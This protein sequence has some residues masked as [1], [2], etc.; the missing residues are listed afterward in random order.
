M[1]M[2]M[3]QT[4]PFISVVIP[5]LNEARTIALVVREAREAF[6][7]SGDPFEIIVA[8]NGS[9]DRSRELAQE[10][11]AK[12]V[13][14]AARGYGAALQ[15]GFSAAQ[16]EII[17]FGD[18]DATYDFSRGP[19]LV[20]HL[21][22]NNAAMVM[23]SRLKGNI[24][25]GAMPLL[26][27]YLGT[28]VLTE[29]INILFHGKITD[30][31]SGFRAFR[32]KRLSRWRAHSSGMEFASEMIVGALQAGDLILEVPIALR[33][34]HGQRAA[35]LSTWRDGMRHLLVILSRAPQGFS[36]SGIVLLGLSLSVALPCMILGPR[37]IGPLAIFD[38]HSLI[39]SVLV[40]FF[41]A[42]AISYGLILDAKSP[43][44][45]PINRFFLELSEV[46]LLKIM[47]GLLLMIAGF[48]GFIGAVWYRHGFSNIHFLRTSLTMLYVSVV[49]G[50][51][52]IGIFFSQIHRRG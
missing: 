49:V 31:N 11:G 50:S 35:H 38:F 42:Q 10:A 19:D 20:R 37:R 24:A 46:T 6:S 39:F 16:G 12:V 2:N 4:E 51:L 18:A 3:T 32:R 36:Y 44:P 28:P 52:S 25:P 21:R 15:G 40:G 22:E 7:Q 17:L 13:A 45:L 34:D 5:C 1:A 33:K 14:V 30:C 29:L 8:D 9:S 41:G 26:H 43:A 23:G 48:A 47:T 27:R